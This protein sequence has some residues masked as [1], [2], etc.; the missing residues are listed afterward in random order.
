M[1]KTTIEAV[2]NEPIETIWHIVTDLRN[3][4]WRSDLSKIEVLEDKKVFIEYTNQGFPTKFVITT[5]EPLKLYAFTMDNE[6]ISGKWVG[7]F[8]AISET[9]TKIIFVEDV[10]SKKIY[11]KPFVKGYLN[12]QQK[13]YV[14]DLTNYLTNKK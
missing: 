13:R 4:E 10:S 7:E 11:M 8:Q 3:A 9:K 6:N 1:V 2:F 12:K 5:Y 14:E